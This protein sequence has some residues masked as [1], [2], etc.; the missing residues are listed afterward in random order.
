MTRRILRRSAPGAV[1]LV[2]ALTLTLAAC[3]SGS[4]PEAGGTEPAEIDTDAPVTISVGGKPTTENPEQLADFERQVED[5]TAA[6]PNITIEAEE[7]EWE[8]DTFQAMLAGGTMPTTMNVPFTE[9]GALIERGQVADV[10]DYLAGSEVLEQ[11]NPTVM[12]VVTDDEERVWGVPIAAYTMGLLY[13]RAL[14]EQAGLD[15]DDPPQTWDD[16]RSAAQAIDEATDAQGFAT[17]TLDNTGGWVL[18]TTSYGFGSTIQ[19]D[20]GATATLDNPATAEVL[21]L[22]RT[23]R[24]EDNTMGS[25][26]LLNYD[27]AV[28]AFASGQIGMFI[29]GAD[30][31]GNMVTNR[32]MAPEDFGVAPLPQTEDGI[33]TLG[34]GTISIVNPE[35][36][37]EE[38]AAA[39]AWIEFKSFRQYTDEEIAVANAEARVADG[40]PVG[41]P[42][43]RVVNEEVYEQYSEW[44]TPLI[45]VP[46]E[47]WE[48]YLS[49]VEEIPLI[50]EPAT[51]AQELYALLDPVVQAVLTRED[52]DIEQLLAD[53]Q[54]S[55]QA[56]IDA[57]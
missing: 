5:F 43:L 24:W 52:A 26:F 7:T 1:T 14:F 56:A 27:D 8:A 21:E 18:T 13:N 16:V 25:N 9:I 35:A 23:L 38:I 6:Y 48:L 12:D 30:N 55:A 37:P 11:L 17:M 20:D 29:Q 4:D 47:N 41:A 39:L 15:P 44:V 46:R 28:N 36:T 50:P 49:T 22:Y 51:K 34:G 2:A 57:G 10:T 33:G 40:L 54:G 45:N 32:G 31:Y 19:S 53:A 3:S 42:G